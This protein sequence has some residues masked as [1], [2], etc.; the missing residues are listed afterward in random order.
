MFQIKRKGKKMSDKAKPEFGVCFYT[1]ENGYGNPG[2]RAVCG[3][4]FQITPEYTRD[5]E[6]ASVGKEVM[7]PHCKEWSIKDRAIDRFERLPAVDKM[8]FY[9]ELINQRAEN[10]VASARAE[11]DQKKWLEMQTDLVALLNHVDE[12]YY[13]DRLV[14]RDPG[15]PLVKSEHDALNP[16][17]RLKSR[18]LSC[19][20]W[21]IVDHKKLRTELTTV[22]NAYTAIFRDFWNLEKAHR[23]LKDKHIKEVNAAQAT[24]DL[25]QKKSREL[26]KEVYDLKAKNAILREN[27]SLTVQTLTSDPS[28]FSTIFTGRNLNTVERELLEKKGHLEAL[29]G[30]LKE[31]RRITSCPVAKSFTAH[32]EELM[33]KLDM[34]RALV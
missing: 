4:I 11:N 14:T 6:F 10:T 27:L 25:E 21:L 34:Y 22:K 7:C 5:C 28:S 23:D 17:Q 9:L 29:E 19:L 16:E 12:C 18:A 30:L 2:G 3:K 33:E 15:D 26:E 32:L 13:I 1:K 24:I 20:R 8:D 31:W